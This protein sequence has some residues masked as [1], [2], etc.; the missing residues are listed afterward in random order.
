M[1]EYTQIVCPE[2]RIS[3]PIDGSATIDDSIL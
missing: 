1:T 3:S 2:E